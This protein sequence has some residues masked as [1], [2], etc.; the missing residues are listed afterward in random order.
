MHKP[1]ISVIM[2]VY[3]GAAFLAEAVDSVLSQSHEHLELIAVDDGSTDQSLDILRKVR[4]RRL[5]IVEQAHAGIIE[6]V[7]NGIARA[8]G[9][10]IARMDCDDVAM[11]DRLALQLDYLRSGK[12]EV[13]GGRVKIFTSERKLGQGFRNYEKWLNSLVAHQE[14]IQHIF[15]E[16]PI[17]S[18]TLFISSQKLTE[19]GQYD[20]E[21]YPDDYNL[22]LKC[23]V[24]GL[25]F[26]KASEE[27]IKWRDHPKRMS[28][29]SP[30]IADQRF[31]DLKAAYF[32]QFYKETGRP[33]II[34]GIG[35]NGKKLYKAF[36]KKCFPISG[37][38]AAEQY[39]KEERLYGLPLKPFYQ[40]KY[41]FFLISAAARGARDEIVGVLESRG[42]RPIKDYMAFC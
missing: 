15:I 9:E 37:F 30:E 41:P 18:P 5:R 36:T 21:I 12:A 34:W 14:I 31:F 6:A 42:C 27:V 13:V 3:N 39:I 2:P 8:R 11:R 32:S 10:Y 7:N 25:R 4:D 22:I 1:L 29:T 28:R 40:Y 23:F 35:G 17:P 16:N 24:R 26:G 38:T 19:V 33:L 20:P